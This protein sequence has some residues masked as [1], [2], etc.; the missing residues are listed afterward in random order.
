MSEGSQVTVVAAADAA[1]D[2]LCPL[3]PILQSIA[4][5]ELTPNKPHITT[6]QS[7]HHCH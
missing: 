7:M 2:V 1:A 5:K 4:Q 6:A 3:T